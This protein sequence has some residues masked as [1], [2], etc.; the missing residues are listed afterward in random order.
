[1]PK[2]SRLLR[3]PGTYGDYVVIGYIHSTLFKH[4]EGGIADLD[5]HNRN[6]VLLAEPEMQQMWDYHRACLG[7]VMRSSINI[8]QHQYKLLMIEQ[9]CNPM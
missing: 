1:M 5:I 6:C 2:E 9:R 3:L 4:N 7:K 8:H